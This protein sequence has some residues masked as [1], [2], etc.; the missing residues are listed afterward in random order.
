M[1]DCVGYWRMCLYLSKYTLQR[2]REREKERER[3]R[4]RERERERERG[5]IEQRNA[6]KGESNLIKKPLFIFEQNG[7]MVLT[8]I[9]RNRKKDRERERDDNI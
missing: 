4:E 9:F 1:K 6:N 2:E 7:T 8:R 3:K 5:I